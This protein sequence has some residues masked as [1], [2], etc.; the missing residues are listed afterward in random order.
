MGD[1]RR[2]PRAVPDISGIAPEIRKIGFSCRRCGACCRS[3][4]DDSG[5]VF[6]SREEVEALVASGA[7]SWDQVA[8]PFPEFVPCGDGAEVTFGWCIRHE[9]ERCRFLSD[10]GCTVYHT[11]PWI[12]RTYPFA[13]VNGNLTVSDCP[14]LGGPIPEEE[15]LAL[16][17]ALVGRARFE[18]R[19]EE[20]VRE[21]FGSATIP[22][23][24][25]CVVDTAGIRVLDD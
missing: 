19:E 16:A 10:R 24:K 11:R 17:E 5:L 14:G 4:P 8:R 15:A 12:C 18:A 9:G 2:D 6:V 23:G 20:R 1:R 22:A 3:G 25:R 21:I 7:G 13:L